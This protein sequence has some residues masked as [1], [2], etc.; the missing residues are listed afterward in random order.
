MFR[1][2]FLC[3]FRLIWFDS[4]GAKSSCMLVK[5]SDVS[6]LIDPGAAVM[7]GSFPASPEDKAAWLR[8]A[9][10]EIKRAVVEAD[11][12]VVT[13]Y[14]YD[15]F[16]REPSFYR[17][18][19]LLA[20]NPNCYINDSQ[21]RRAEDFYSSLWSFFKKTSLEK[22]LE[23]PVVRD[24][25]NPLSE[26]DLALRKDFGD[27]SERRRELLDKGLKWFRGRVEKWRSLKWI[28]E[29][30]SRELRVE[31]ADGRV[32]EFG[33]TILKCSKPLF[34]GIEFSRLGWV[35]SVVI[36]SGKWK[37]MYS[38]DLNGPII[39][40]Y[41]EYI[42]RENPDVLVL[43]GPATYMIPYTLNLINLRRS[44]ENICRIIRETKTGL[45]ILDHHLLR[46]K[47]YRK[48]LEEVYKT[49]ERENKRV[50]SAAEYLGKTPKILEVTKR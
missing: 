40:D 34:H 28:P 32:F 50:V 26:L 2:R 10:E 29:L 11:V 24:Y 18:K 19:L 37:F 9:W 25:P 13:H 47:L 7:H 8:S 22:E 16:S 15:H 35:F 5:T 30:K 43:D 3:N 38:S 4:L 39:E 48:R 14:H 36:E 6:V 12:I 23:E 20:K 1:G 27:Y 42:I 45:T 31:F 33:G 17:G 44:I 41:A 46:D 21:R 49:A